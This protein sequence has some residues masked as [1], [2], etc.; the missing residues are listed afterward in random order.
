MLSGNVTSTSPKLE[1]Q[2]PRRRIGRRARA[3]IAALAGVV[4]ALFIAGWMGACFSQFASRQEEGSSLV[5]R[6]VV[7]R[8]PSRF[9]RDTHLPRKN[10]LL[11]CGPINLK[12]FSPAKDLVRI[13]DRRVWWESDH[14]HGPE[15]DHVINQALE[16]PLRKLINLVDKRGGVL[17]VY[18]AYR[19]TGV[20][21]SNSLH[22]EGRAIDLTC[23][24]FSLEVLAKLCWA[25]GFDWVYYEGPTKK[26]GDHIHCSVKANKSI[27]PAKPGA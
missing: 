10:E 12:T 26:G 21:L 18:D 11:A 13:D 3:A 16:E 22:K 19:A 27:P 5:Y 24:G 6:R 8:Q 4:V 25:A 20:H 15:D 2:P 17:K 7:R 9:P 14:R 1:I 23:E